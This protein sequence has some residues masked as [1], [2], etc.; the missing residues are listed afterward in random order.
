MSGTTTLHSP[1]PEFYRGPTL[2]LLDLVCDSRQP[3]RIGT[4]RRWHCAG[5]RRVAAV[6]KFSDCDCVT[7][8]PARRVQ[9]RQRF[10]DG[11]KGVRLR[12]IETESRER[13]IRKA[14]AKPAKPEKQAKSVTKPATKPTKRAAK[15]KKMPPV[16]EPSE[17]T[18]QQAAKYGLSVED[19]LDAIA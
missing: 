1:Q 14:L 9:L 16:K 8:I 18:K 7:H 11:S 19:Y 15:I 6:V 3:N 13:A 5:G 2:R 10:I 17:Y 4:F 12:S